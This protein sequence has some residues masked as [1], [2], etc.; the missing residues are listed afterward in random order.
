MTVF[1]TT[2]KLTRWAHHLILHSI[3]FHVGIFLPARWY[4]SSR[5]SWPWKA[6]V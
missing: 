5:D 6:E 2:V 4:F 3:P 1:V